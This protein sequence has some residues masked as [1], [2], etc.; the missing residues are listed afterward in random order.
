MKNT[1]IMALSMA[2]FIVAMCDCDRVKCM[3][4]DV[5]EVM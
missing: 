5:K 1:M 4:Q 2:T 3:I